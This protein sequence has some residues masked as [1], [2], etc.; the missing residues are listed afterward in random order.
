MKSSSPVVE[1]GRITRSADE[2]E[3]SRSCQSTMFSSACL[4]SS[5][6]ITRA[7]PQS[8]SHLMGFRLWGIALEPFCPG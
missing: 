1:S 2:C 7:S 5:P 4:Q 8:C 3:M 6:R